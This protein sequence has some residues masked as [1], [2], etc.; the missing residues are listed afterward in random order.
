[1][2]NQHSNKQPTGESAGESEVIQDCKRVTEWEREGD[3]QVTEKSRR[4]NSPSRSRPRVPIEDASATGGVSSHAP[5][6]TLRSTADMKKLSTPLPGFSAA[7]VLFAVGLAASAGGWIA[8]VGVYRAESLSLLAAK[9]AEVVLQHKLSALE[10]SSKEDL[11]SAREEAA[12]ELGSKAGVIALLESQ[13]KDVQRDHADALQES[14]ALGKLG[15]AVTHHPPGTSRALTTLICCMRFAPA[16]IALCM[17]VAHPGGK[18]P[19]GKHPGKHRDY[20][21]NPVNKR[22]ACMS[23]TKPS[24]RFSA[25]GA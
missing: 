6:A 12:S 10:Q 4:G 5:E 21:P 14:R 22:H 15:N 13:A 19:G 24:E 1:M 18:H 20:T 23:A 11:A 17:V 9:D 25:Y 16:R 7:I 3:H 2:G 8:H